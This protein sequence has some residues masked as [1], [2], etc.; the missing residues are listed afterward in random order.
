MVRRIV[1]WLLALPLLGCQGFSKLD[2]SPLG[3]ASWQRPDDVI[4]ALGLQPT[5]RVADLG[6]GEGYFVPYLSGAVPQG[7]VYAVDVDPDALATLEEKFGGD[8]DNVEV[9]HA[10]FDDPGLPDGAIDLVLVVNTYHHID[11]RE[12]YFRRLRSDLSPR[13]RLALLEPSPEAGGILGLFTPKDHGTP[14]GELD[15]E[16]G[17]AGYVRS[18]T[19]DILP[20]QQFVIFRPAR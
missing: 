19:H 12:A 17:A 5:D 1:P 6:A 14:L 15:R 10:A 13:G 8:A 20:I 7:R 2:F 18:E 4:A 16:L 11:D 9:V 3:R